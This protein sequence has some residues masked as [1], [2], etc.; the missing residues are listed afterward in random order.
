MNALP[1]SIFDH[2]LYTNG[3]DP[4]A[5]GRIDGTRVDIVRRVNYRDSH[6]FMTFK[7]WVNDDY[8]SDYSLVDLM[9]Q[10]PAL[11][12]SAGVWDEYVTGEC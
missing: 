4:G 6:W 8:F 12:Y 7:A 1:Q 2:L 10:L 9:A 11:D 5:I 3:A